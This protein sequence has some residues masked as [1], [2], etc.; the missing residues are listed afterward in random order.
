MNRFWMTVCCVLAALI[1]LA[2]VIVA[3]LYPM[4]GRTERGVVIGTKTFD[5]QYI[6]GHVIA[7]RL[8]AAGIVAT[9]REGL[10]STVIFRA[11]AAGD[12]R[13]R[14]DN[15]RR[16]LEYNEDD[17]T[18]TAFLRDWMATEGPLLPSIEAWTERSL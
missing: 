18:A 16:L 11:L 12:E 1:G 13:F 10:G 8:Q 14:D 3:S 15:R 5:E 4:L 6:L 17:V 7:D 2:I 9:R